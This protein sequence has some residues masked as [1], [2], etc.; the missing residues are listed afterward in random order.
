M[1]DV[2]L[3]NPFH[4]AGWE[5]Q[6]AT[7]EDRT[8]SIFLVNKTIQ[9]YAMTMS[10]KFT[11][12]RYTWPQEPQEQGLDHHEGDGSHPAIT[13]YN[14]NASINKSVNARE[15]SYIYSV[16]KDYVYN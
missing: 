15:L 16:C 2:Q 6:T 9:H 4:D 10:V 5:Q 14:I 3:T 1:K 8:T 13:N 11:Y 7:G 12:K